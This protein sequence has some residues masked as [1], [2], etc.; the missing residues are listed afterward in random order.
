MKTKIPIRFYAITFSWTW[1]CWLA[2]MLSSRLGIPAINSAMAIYGP[3]LE[4]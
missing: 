2:H 3:V 4:Y 1:F